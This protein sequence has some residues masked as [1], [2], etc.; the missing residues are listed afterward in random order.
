MRNF[1]AEM[2]TWCYY[3]NMKLSIY[4]FKAR[5]L[6]FATEH[7]VSCSVN[8]ENYVIIVIV[9][10]PFPCCPAEFCYLSLYFIYRSMYRTFSFV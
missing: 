4:Y 6:Y 3:F 10:H 2:A 8:N 1:C 7:L 9:N 5:M